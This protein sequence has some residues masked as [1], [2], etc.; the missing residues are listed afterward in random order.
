MGGMVQHQHRRILEIKVS[1]ES[2]NE[3]NLLPRSK[4]M[5]AI[6]AVDGSSTGT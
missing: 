3:I 4:V 6:D 2:M 5:S 1:K